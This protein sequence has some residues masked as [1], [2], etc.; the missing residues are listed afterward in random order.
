[1]IILDNGTTSQNLIHEFHKYVSGLHPLVFVESIFTCF[2]DIF[3]G[4]LS[5]QLA[6]FTGRCCRILGGTPD[7]NKHHQWKVLVSC[8]DSLWGWC[9]WLSAAEWWLLMTHSC[10][11]L[12][13]LASAKQ[14]PSSPGYVLSVHPQASASDLTTW[15]MTS[16][17]LLSRAS[18]V[19]RFMLQN[20]PQ[21]EDHILA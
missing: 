2:G 16:K 5:T 19:V 21:G 3:R 11:L 9:T 15:T 20:F 6:L 10:P 18:S 7:F 8:S 1:M 13:A 4:H 12:R 14:K 17:L